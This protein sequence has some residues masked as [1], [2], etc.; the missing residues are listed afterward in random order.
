LYGAHGSRVS[1]NYLLLARILKKQGKYGDET[2]ELFER[3]LAN[4]T[5][6]E[7]PDGANIAVVNHEIGQFHYKIALTSSIVHIKRTQLL[8]AKSY[9]DEA[10]RIE[11]KIHSPTHP[12]RVATTL[13]S[14]LL[15]DLS[16][17]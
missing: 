5:R 17:V 1:V 14:N 9:S 11:I 7:G 16:R 4:V 10:V 12:N 6:N 13:L 8:L 3:S 2:K 15:S